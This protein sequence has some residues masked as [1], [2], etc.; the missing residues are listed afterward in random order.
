MPGIQFFFRLLFQLRF[1]GRL[2]I[3]REQFQVRGAALEED[4]INPFL[5]LLDTAAGIEFLGD[6][7]LGISITWLAGA[8]LGL[9][10]SRHRA[11]DHL[12]G[13][14]RSFAAPGGWNTAAR[15]E[16]EQRANPGS[17]IHSQGHL[18]CKITGNS[19]ERQAGRSVNLTIE[20]FYF[21]ISPSH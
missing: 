10:R 16:K 9:L 1:A 17:P 8:R 11:L 20:E 4:T 3:D 2:S 18:V 5:A 19:G 7:Q 13:G 14:Q 6:G 21:P 12:V 15:S